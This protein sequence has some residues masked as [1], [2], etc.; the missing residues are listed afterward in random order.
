[1]TYTSS[2]PVSPNVSPI[3][4]KRPLIASARLKTEVIPRDPGTIIPVTLY[5]AVGA[6]AFI[7]S[8]QIMSLGANIKSVLRVYY[9]LPLSSTYDL[10]TERTIPA[11]ATAAADEKLQDNPLTVD[12]P[13]VLFPASP[14]PQVPNGGLRI[15]PGVEIAV[16]LGV[17]IASGVVVTIFGGEY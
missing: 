5:T 17:A 10:F 15:P 6:G 16:G 1:M 11:I 7:E 13:K 14:N 8:L 9:K 3:F 12:L 2:I 4:I